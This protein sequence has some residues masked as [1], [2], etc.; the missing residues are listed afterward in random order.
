MPGLIPAGTTED[1][2]HGRSP[3]HAALRGTA[4]GRC[5]GRVDAAGGQ[6]GRY[7]PGGG[8]LGGQAV[9]LPEAVGAVA[10]FV[11]EVHHQ[12]LERIHCHVPDQAPNPC[13]N[14]IP[15]TKATKRHKE[16]NDCQSANA[17]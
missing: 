8:G 9:V 7:G 12:E 4:D 5:P 17:G 10:V 1:E 15:K 6:V 13:N 14:N 2:N 3:G 16:S 11:D